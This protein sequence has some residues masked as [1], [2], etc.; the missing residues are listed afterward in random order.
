MTKKQKIFGFLVILPLI[1]VYLY[2]SFFDY[3]GNWLEDYQYY[4]KFGFFFIAIFGTAWL[5]KLTYKAQ[6]FGSKIW[7]FLEVI[8][9]LALLVYAYLGAALINFNL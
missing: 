1:L 4:F 6:G 5:V 2:D 9:L 8:L 3:S 7:L